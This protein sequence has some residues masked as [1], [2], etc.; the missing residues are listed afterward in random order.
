MVWKGA[1]REGGGGG[2]G[3]V[4]GEWQIVAWL[5]EMGLDRHLMSHVTHM[6]E[7]Y[8]IHK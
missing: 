3:K 4:D 7:S 2:G 6:N 1:G 5:A 8:H